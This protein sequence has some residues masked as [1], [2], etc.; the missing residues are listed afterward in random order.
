MRSSSI[1]VQQNLIW[2]NLSLISAAQQMPDGLCAGSFLLHE[3]K[4]FGDSRMR[5][6]AWPEPG[7][8]FDSG[9]LETLVRV[10]WHGWTRLSTR[11]LTLVESLVPAMPGDAYKSSKCPEAPGQMQSRIKVTGSVLVWYLVFSFPFHATYA[12]AR[13]GLLGAD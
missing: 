1:S 7:S 6:L 4:S 3:N 13:R 8:L 5:L 12:G 2:F 11:L 10:S 9:H